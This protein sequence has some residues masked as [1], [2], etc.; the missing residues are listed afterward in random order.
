MNI[1]SSFSR[2][3]RDSYRLSRQA[4]ITIFTVVVLI[5]WHSGNSYAVGYALHNDSILELEI[6]RDAP[7]RIIIENEK[8]SD[9]F[10]HPAESAEAV[11]HS[12]GC[13]FILP[14]KENGKI[15][16]TLIGESGTTQDIALRFVKKQPNPI[17]L[18][19]LEWTKDN[20]I[21]NKK[22]K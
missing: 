6:A 16:I 14:Q 1:I 7:T 8:I 19:K 11:I 22:E 17:R 3:L 13:L 15:Y 12:S 20:Q 18:L 5:T 10:V 2:F 9:I 4:I 21:I